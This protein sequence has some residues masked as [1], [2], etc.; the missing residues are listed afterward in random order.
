[1]PIKQFKNHDSMKINLT[2]FTFAFLLFTF[3][4]CN[5]NKAKIDNDLKKYF[6]A[7]NADG[8]FTMLDNGTGKITVYNMGMDTTRVVPGGTFNIVTS[9]IG[10]ETGKIPDEKMVIKWDGTKH[11]QNDWNQDLDLKQAFKFNAEPYFSEVA[12]RVGPDSM[13]L[14]VDSIAYGNK[15]FNIPTDSTWPDIH[16]KISPDEQLG[17]VKKLFF[18]QL[19]FRKSAQQTIRNM[20][21][22]VDNTAY[23]LSYAT[24]EGLDQNNNSIGWLIGWVQENGHVFFFV[25]LLKSKD[26]NFDMSA[27]CIS[28]TK[29]ILKNYGFL[30]GKK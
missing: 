16:L 30:E 21:L 19:P 26:P 22:Q 27:S 20:M 13:K 25:T 12:R 14:Y 17:L 7:K 1:M 23:K 5:V 11:S 29:D 2:L 9:L 24:G 8:C 28:I 10:L 4:G 18:D 15:N 6:D 3:L